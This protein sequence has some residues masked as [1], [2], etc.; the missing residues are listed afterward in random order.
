MI[1]FQLI[2]PGGV[3]SYLFKPKDISK[4]KLISN[5]NMA[6]PVIFVYEWLI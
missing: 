4:L 5:L 6:R 2:K 1:N 3:K